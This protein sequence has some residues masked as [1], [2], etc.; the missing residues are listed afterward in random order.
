M[1]K[2]G[3]L[4]MLSQSSTDFKIKEFIM[5]LFR[6]GYSQEKIQKKVLKFFQAFD[7]SRDGN[8]ESMQKKLDLQKKMNTKIKTTQAQGNWDKSELENLFLDC[9]DQ[10]KKEALRKKTLAQRSSNSLSMMIMQEPAGMVE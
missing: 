6:R 9:I 4:D 5:D 10:Y 3:S 8:I 2:F 1:G 7:L